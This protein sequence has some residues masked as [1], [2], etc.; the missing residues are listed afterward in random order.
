MI[1]EAGTVAIVPFPFIDMAVAKSRPALVLSVRRFNEENASTIF[2]MITTAK[3]SAWPS[4]ILLKQ[5]TTAGLNEECYVRWKVFTLPNTLI[6]RTTGSLS[7]QDA[8]LVRTA[9]RGLFL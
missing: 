9:S 5:P 7:L 8:D 6:R 3:R 2:A 1:C 4:D